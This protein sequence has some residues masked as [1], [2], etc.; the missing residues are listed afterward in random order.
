MPDV[1]TVARSWLDRLP[2]TNTRIMITLA[3]V[4]ATAVR[5]LGWGAPGSGGT[6]AGWDSWLVFVAVMAGI[7][8][9]QYIGKR[10]SDWTYAAAKTQ[11]T[12]RV[13]VT[14]PAPVTVTA[15]GETTVGASAA[16]G[17]A[18]AQLAALS[19]ASPS[20]MMPARPAPPLD[21]AAVLSDTAPA[22]AGHDERSDR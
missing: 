5:F 15:T 2:T 8:V 21:P 3:I 12:P 7:D 9:S 4:V 22:R 1:E 18:S 14:T 20:L 6:A 13:S 11:T 16:A 10:F 19:F 17:E